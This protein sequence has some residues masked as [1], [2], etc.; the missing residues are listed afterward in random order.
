MTYTDLC[1][2][3][4]IDL[5]ELHEDTQEAMLE[6]MPPMGTIRKNPVDISGS[7]YVPDVLGNSLKVIGRD[8]NIDSI[9]FVFDV[10]FML[11]AAK[12]FGG[13]PKMIVNNL[14]T[15]LSDAKDQLNIPILC[16]IPVS[17]EGLAFEELRLY[18][19]G[20]LEKKNLPSF[21][22]TERATR[23]IR[24]TYEYNYFQKRHTSHS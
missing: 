22:N 10:R 5:P 8:P 7:V 23:A 4:G 1:V 21:L 18:L 3:E 13:D 15:G 6:F 2:K 12:W 14:V 19:K 16:I 17:V 20:V 24:N 9:I 11:N